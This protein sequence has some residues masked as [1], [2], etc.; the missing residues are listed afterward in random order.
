MGSLRQAVES[1]FAGVAY[2][3]RNMDGEAKRILEEDDEDPK[4]RK[5]AERQM[6]GQTRR[7][8]LRAE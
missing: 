3:E 5:R 4:P 1:T 8:G 2:A 6:A 7:Q